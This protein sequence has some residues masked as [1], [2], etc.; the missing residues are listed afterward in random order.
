MGWFLS[1]AGVLGVGGLG[2]AAWLLGPAALLGFGRSALGFLAKIPWQVWAAAAVLVLIV[3]LFISR[4]HALERAKADEVQLAT[5]CAATR[6]A[7]DNP[8]LDCK[9][10]PAQIRE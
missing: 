7:A 6:T 9:F 4:A 2:A 1:I 10:V 5:I 3:F 8:K